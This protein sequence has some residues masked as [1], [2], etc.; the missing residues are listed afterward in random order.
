MITF[1]ADEAQNEFSVDPCA[2]DS[3][4]AT[5]GVICS[6]LAQQPV[7]KRKAGAEK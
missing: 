3:Q 7:Q 1:V 4:Y 6:V 2:Y 5:T